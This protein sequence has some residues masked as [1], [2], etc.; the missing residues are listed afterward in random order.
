MSD[1]AKLK[2]LQTKF[3]AEK[4]LFLGDL[5]HSLDNSDCAQAAEYF[6]SNSEIEF[7]LVPG[8]HDIFTAEKYEEYGLNVLDEDYRLRSFRF[9]H[10]PVEHVDNYFLFC[11]HIHPGVI[12]AGARIPAF[13]KTDNFLV[14]PSFGSFTGSVR[15]KRVKDDRMFAV[16]EGSVWEV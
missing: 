4:V 16:L 10:E 12:L 14:L 6:K 11:G 2:E 1:L 7:Q 13:W 3:S 9:V 5:F 8:N 15:V